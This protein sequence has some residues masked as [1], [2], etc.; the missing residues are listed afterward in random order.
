MGVGFPCLMSTGVVGVGGDPCLMFREGVRGYTVMSNGH[1]GPP[2][3]RQTRVKYSL[4]IAQ[5]AHVTTNMPHQQLLTGEA[6]AFSYLQ[7]PGFAEPF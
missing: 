6:G 5:F 2:C 7:N 3:D 4:Q 1:K